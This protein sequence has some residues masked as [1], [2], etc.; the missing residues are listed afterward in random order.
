MIAALS[1]ASALYKLKLPGTRWGA[2]LAFAFYL[3][4]KQIIHLI[5]PGIAHLKVDHDGFATFLMTFAACI[6]A[7]SALYFLVERPFLIFRD[8]IAFARSNQASPLVQDSRPMT[9]E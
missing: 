7:S 6:V 1:P 3:T 4:H 2:T 5:Q 8:R 9:S